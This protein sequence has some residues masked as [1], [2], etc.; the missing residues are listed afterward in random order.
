MGVAF[1]RP[2]HYLPGRRSGEIRRFDSLNVQFAA[3]F[4]GQA[5][6]RLSQRKECQRIAEIIDPRDGT[7]GD[8]SNGYLTSSAFLPWKIA[9]RQAQNVMRDRDWVLIV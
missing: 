5:T 6:V 3:R 4:H 2:R 7:R 9:R 8:R 1:Q